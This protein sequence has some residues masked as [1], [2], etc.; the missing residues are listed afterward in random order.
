[1]I[2][3][4]HRAKWNEKK[5]FS[6][7]KEGRGQGHGIDYKPWIYIQDF[8]SRGKVSRVLG[9]KNERIH[10]FFSNHETSFFYIMDFKEDVIDIQEQYPL[11]DVLETVRIAERIGIKHP[12][13]N[14]S[15]YP[16]VLTSDFVITTRQGCFVRTIKEAEELSKKRVI[17]KLEIERRYWKE[18]NVDWKIITEKD[19]NFEEA[20]N[21]EW[22]SRAR[23]LPNILDYEELIDALSYF[24]MLYF[25]SNAS[26]V[27]IANETELY[28]H[29]DSGLGITIF[30]YLILIRQI[31][32]D[33]SKSLN[34]S[35][36]RIFAEND[37][38]WNVK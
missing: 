30:Q 3:T 17:E 8:S 16:Y 4:K 15:K 11:L 35:L 5:Y 13:D 19:I 24:K 23:C 18:R 14:K 21:I 7:L 2:I 34:L 29:L 9:L 27:N 20:K 36:P 1:M 31:D 28:F 38:S 12:R 32:I 10:H 33:M 25:N 6:R 22:I 26:I 37:L